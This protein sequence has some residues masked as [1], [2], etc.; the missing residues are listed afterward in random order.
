MSRGLALGLIAVAGLGMAVQAS[1]EVLE[2]QN[3]RYACDRGVEVPATFVTGPEDALVV[4]QIEGRQILLYQEVAAS[5]ARYA[6]PSDGAG[7]VLWSKG[8]AATI[9]W[10]EGG[11]ETELLS[12]TAQM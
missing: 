8:D 10:R 12:C 9:Y 2:V 11:Q 7:Y 3:L 5:G 4:I 6:W 1:A